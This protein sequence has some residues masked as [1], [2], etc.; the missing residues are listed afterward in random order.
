VAISGWLLVA[1]SYRGAPNGDFQVGTGG[2]LLPQE[3]LFVL[4]IA[5]LVWLVG[6]PL[7]SIGGPLVAGISLLSDNSLGV[8]ILH[9]ILVFAIGRQMSGLLNPGL[10]L[11]FVGFLVLTVGGLLAATLA[12]LL[13]R[14]TP[15]AVS[16][17]VS[18]RS[19]AAPGTRAASP[20]SAA[21]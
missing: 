13:L 4:S 16:I 1:V 2:F 14:A 7:M 10:P 8:Y 21:G 3:P 9:P 11:S 12:S 20:R 6:R 17:G 18:R 5:T 15:L 19:L